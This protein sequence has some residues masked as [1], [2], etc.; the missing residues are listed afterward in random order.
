MTQLLLS[1]YIKLSSASADT[2]KFVRVDST[3]AIKKDVTFAR[4]V[5]MFNARIGTYSVPEYRFTVRADIP[6]SDGDPSGQRLSFDAI[7]RL[8]VKATKAQ[9]E[10]Q[11]VSVKELVNSAEFADAVILQLFPCEGACT[12]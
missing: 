5:G 4:K 2:L 8:P 9:L 11:L 3:Q 1:N 10:E 7:V 6:N 12:V